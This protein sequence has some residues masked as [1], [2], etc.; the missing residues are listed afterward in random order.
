MSLDR[1]DIQRLYRDLEEA[2]M[3]TH[4]LFQ[5]LE[6]QREQ[7]SDY[8]RER[9]AESLAC[10]EC[11]IDSPPSLAVAIQQGWTRIQADD[12]LGHNFLGICPCC[13]SE[14]EQED[15]PSETVPDVPKASPKPEKGPPKKTLF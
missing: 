3:A 11:D 1:D 5:T 13:R 12:A 4:A 10:A 6:A 2:T 15:K 14:Q 9:L 8:V 7:I